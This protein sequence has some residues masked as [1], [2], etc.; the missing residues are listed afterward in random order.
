V[1]A[2]VA[3]IADLGVTLAAD[4]GGRALLDWAERRAGMIGVRPDVPGGALGAALAALRAAASDAGSAEEAARVAVTDRRLRDAEAQ[5]RR[6]DRHRRSST[7]DV[8]RAG[9]RA[10]VAELDG[11][12]LLRYIVAGRELW[13][14]VVEHGRAR[15]RR[16]EPVEV[17]AAHVDRLRFA[18]GRQAIGGAAATRARSAVAAAADALAGLLMP[19]SLAG[20]AAVVVPDGPLHG[21]AWMA[22]GPLGERRVTVTPSLGAWVSA[23]RRAAASAPSGNDSAL[24]VAGPGLPGAEAEI[25]SAGGAWGAGATALG[26]TEARVADVL[27]ALGRAR[28]AHFAC[29]GHFRGDSPLFSSLTLADGP[30]TVHDI[31]GLEHV[32]ETFVLGACD[33]GES[34]AVAGA[35]VLGLAA[36]CLAAGASSVIASVLPLPDGAAAPVMAEV[37]GRIA[38]GATA[39]TALAEV[40]VAARSS[41]DSVREAVAM[42]LCCFGAD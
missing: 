4:R 3:A 34:V 18:L 22:L 6:L 23:T 24:F 13:L 31:L 32:P 9:L 20:D 7:S 16:L 11:R 12:T 36:G 26:P 10:A 17:I 35:E 14:V 19:A 27:A 30:L 15:H 2:T 29:H 41:E 33:V 39:A 37:V 42:S 40:A 8:G 25:A 5:V 38:A 1:A 21:V 28:L